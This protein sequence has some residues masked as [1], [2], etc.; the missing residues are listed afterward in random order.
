MTK[1]RQ[2]SDGRAAFVV[3]FGIARIDLLQPIK[4]RRI[5]WL[6]LVEDDVDG[7]HWMTDPIIALLRWHVKVLQSPAA[8]FLV[9]PKAKQPVIT[10]RHR[11]LR[12]VSGGRVNQMRFF[13]V[14]SG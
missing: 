14:F 5:S 9:T 1:E 3:G 13:A 10:A 2:A 4:D 8:L 12:I 7:W 11:R 6:C